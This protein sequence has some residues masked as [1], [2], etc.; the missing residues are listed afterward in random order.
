M[1]QKTVSLIPVGFNKLQIVKV[2]NND[3]SL[4]IAYTIGYPAKDESGADLIKGDEV[5]TVSQF[6]HKPHQ[7]LEKAFQAMR[8]HVAF[9]FGIIDIEEYDTDIFKEYADGVLESTEPKVFEAI[10]KIFFYGYSLGGD[11]NNGIVMNAGM[12]NKMDLSVTLNTPFIKFV[13]TDHKYPFIDQFAS[14]FNKMEQEVYLYMQGKKWFDGQLDMFA[15]NMTITAGKQTITSQ[16]L[17]S[18]AAAA[19]FD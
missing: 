13:E 6:P 17:K 8:L 5:K 11:R 19:I 2:K 1:E 7:H 18:R 15:E 9:L 14:D 10:D 3:S 12:I 16:E 4:N